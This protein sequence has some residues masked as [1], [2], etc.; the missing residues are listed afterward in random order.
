MQSDFHKSTIN[1]PHPS[2]TKQI[3]KAH[4]EV[5]K[6]FTR[7]PYTALIMLGVLA[8]QTIIA[9]FMGQAGLEYWWLAVITAY[10]VGAFASHTMY[11][12][13]HEA[14]HDLVFANKT[15]N[16]FVAIF[17]DLPNLFPA[18]M[19]FKIYHIKHHQHQG[20]YDFD[21]DIANRWEAKLIGNSPLGKA[22]WLLFFPIFQLT[23]PPRLKSIQLFNKWTWINLAFCLAYDAA[24]VYFCGWAGLIYLL[25][26]FFFSIGL[27]PLGARWIQ[28][29]YTYDPEQETASYY[30]PGNI[31][32][33]NVG[34]H[35]EHH[36]FPNIPWNNL[37][38]LKKLAPEFYDNLKYHD[39][40]IK[41]FFQ[42]LF[43]KRYSLFSRVERTADG[44]VGYDKRK[45]T[46]KE[47]EL[48]GAYG[49]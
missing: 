38:K 19:G 46:V 21:A 45:E 18:A 2:R 32:S 41:L 7:N 31:P 11:V 12:I 9:Y 43:D 3:L 36:D 39:S 17:A 15:L 47:P 23:R 29:H 6:L 10:I 28:E 33:L 1:Q 8:L 40:L 14:T 37:P 26:S 20:D 27:H 25:C 35:N 13:I 22:M 5:K 48:H 44:K 42:F 4:P 34:Y 30:G 24:I 16:R 49:G